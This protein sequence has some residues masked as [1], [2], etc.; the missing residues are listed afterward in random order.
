[1]KNMMGKDIN[2]EE[3]GKYYRKRTESGS[4]GKT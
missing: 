1:L 2:H 3:T 4:D